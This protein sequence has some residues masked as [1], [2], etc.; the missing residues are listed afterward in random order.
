MITV[1]KGT[2]KCTYKIVVAVTAAG[3][4]QYEAGTKTVTVKVKG[5]VK[6]R[7]RP[8]W[9]NPIC[10]NLR[11]GFLFSRI[12]VSKIPDTMFRQA[13]ILTEK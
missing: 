10:G 7:R 4:E 9:T 3:N 1:K 8:Y 13:G 6:V 2:K 5:K 12:A 11:S